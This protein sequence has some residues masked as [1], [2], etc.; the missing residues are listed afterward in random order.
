MLK[1]IWKWLQP[2][3]RMDRINALCDQI[4]AENQ[5]Q[6]KLLAEIRSS[7]RHG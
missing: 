7:L 6:L 2:P 5:R 1:K 3:T 4:D